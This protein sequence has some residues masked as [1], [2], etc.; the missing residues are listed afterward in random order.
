MSLLENYFL[1]ALTQLT[2]HYY[3]ILT[4]NMII[5][6][7]IQQG[8]PTP[9]TECLGHQFTMTVVQIYFNLKTSHHQC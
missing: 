3:L 7:E 4:F 8:T 1:I 5:I 9:N 6:E 2:W